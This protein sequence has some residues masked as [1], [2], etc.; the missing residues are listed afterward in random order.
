MSRRGN[1]TGSIIKR[2]NKFFIRVQINKKIFQRLIRDPKTNEPAK[3]KSEAQ[4]ISQ[5]TI[6]SIIKEQEEKPNKTMTSGTPQPIHKVKLSNLFDAY[7]KTYSNNW[8]EKRKYEYKRRRKLFEKEFEF[9]GD[10]IPEN[11]SQWVEERRQEIPERYKSLAMSSEINNP[12]YEILAKT[13]KMPSISDSTIRK[14]LGELRTVLNWAIN[15]RRIE[16]SPLKGYRF[17][18]EPKHRTRVLSTKEIKQLLK[19]LSCINEDWKKLIIKIALYCGMRRGEILALETQDIDF[20]MKAIRLTWTKT[21]DPRDIPIPD[22]L[23]DEL[24]QLVNKRKQEKIKWLFPSP[25]NKNQHIEDIRKFFRTLIKKAG[26]KNF[27][28]NDL[29]HTAATTMLA[30]TNDL[31]SVQLILGHKSINTTQ[32][33]LNPEMDDMRKSINKTFQNI[34]KLNG[35]E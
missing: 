13:D 9:I 34:A 19:T 12:K 14:E 35:S 29:R 8:S 2:K 32:R 18:K 6:E 15:T 30:S 10:I 11:I 21:D 27:R 5:Y 1:Q 31:R 26:I 33:Y 16:Y 25:T 4:R 17:P 20:D 28:F 23:F 24:K 7:W 22:E 3:T